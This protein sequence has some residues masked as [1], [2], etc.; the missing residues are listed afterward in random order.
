MVQHE[1]DMV[2]RLLWR[3]SLEEWI[4]RELGSLAILEGWV[5]VEDMM[6]HRQPRGLI[7]HNLAGNAFILSVLSIVFSL[8]TK[9]QALLKLSHEDPYFGV[10]FADSLALVNP[11]LAQD[12]AVLYWPGD[13]QE[14]YEALFADGLGAVLAWGDAP[15]VQQMAKHAAEHRTRLLDHGPKFGLEVIEEP[16]RKRARSLA[17]SVALDVVP[18]EQHACHSPRVVFVRDGEVNAEEL[19]GLLAEEMDRVSQELP[20][21]QIDCV[22]ASPVLSHREYFMIQLEMAGLGRLFESSGSSWTV[23]F[24]TV[25]PSASDLNACQGRFILV[26]RIRHTD[27][28]LDFI[29]RHHLGPYLQALAYHGSDL[30]FIEEVTL[31]GVCDVTSPGQVNV[32]RAG[33]SHDGLH[34]LAE[35]TYVVSRHKTDE[36]RACDIPWDERLAGQFEGML[37]LTPSLF[38]ETVRET[39]TEVAE[40][41]AR[42]R[43]AARVEEWD[44]VHAYQQ[45][46]P[47]VFKPQAMSYAISVG[48][49]IERYLPRER[50]LQMQALSNQIAWDQVQRQFHPDVTWFEWCITERCNLRCRYCYEESGDGEGEG[51]RRRSELDT[52]DALR[53]VRSLG[54]S[55]RELDRQFVICWS[56]GEPLLRRDLLELMACAREE[57]LL[58]SVATNGVKLTAEVAARFKELE[59][60]NVLISVDSVEPEIHDALRGEGSHARALQAIEHCKRAGLLILVESVATRQNW[61]EIG[62]LKRWTEE[63]V[64]GFYFHRP[65]LEVGRGGACEV[66]MTPDQYRELYHERNRDVLEKLDQGKG[67]QIPLFSI[68]DLV[69]FAHTPSSQ[70]EREHLEW[71]VGCQACRLIHG[72]SSTGDLL[73]CIR[74]KLPLG[75]L[76]EESFVTISQKELYRRFALRQDR[77]G[78][79]A[80][81]EHVELCGGGCMAEVMAQRGDPFA[82]WDRC[83]LHKGKRN[84]P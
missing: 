58:Q 70:R 49:D 74:L 54:R 69:P 51:R 34:N 15:S 75:N 82:G 48:I 46:T 25:M 76:L 33:S 81:C 50:I 84:E 30:R 8:L 13:R 73:P 47:E 56:G 52:E 59:V 38:R 36:E 37:E 55:S 6:L 24:S 64:G 21:D 28:V 83:W 45:Q 5:E 35:L 72:I 16:D 18:W 66:L 43:G 29:D 12:I 79:C 77:G 23:V 78:P 62:K 63:E 53:I 14:T 1:L 42:A 11:E 32:K 22:R 17:N 27:E 67:L 41:T 9:N 71:G 10:R 61:Q 80:D 40:E 7:F 31:R 3:K 20:N 68:F 4:I 65:A 44:L 26:C 19:A 57:G 2:A 60:G 39:I